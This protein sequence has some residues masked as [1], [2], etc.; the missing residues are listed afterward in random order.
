MEFPALCYDKATAGH[1]T[2]CLLDPDTEEEI[3]TAR[4]PHFR[5]VEEPGDLRSPVMELS[6]IAWAPGDPNM[7]TTPKEFCRMRDSTPTLENT[8]DYRDRMII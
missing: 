8:A 4:Y 1:P 5:E 6:V 3:A 2:A 7:R